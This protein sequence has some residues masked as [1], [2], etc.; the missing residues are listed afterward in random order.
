MGVLRRIVGIGF[1]FIFI[2]FLYITVKNRLVNISA[3]SFY[4]DAS[5]LLYSIAGMILWLLIYEIAWEWLFRKVCA[6]NTNIP[7]HITGKAFFKSLLA[8]YTPGQVWQIVVRTESLTQYQIPRKQTIHSVLYEQLDFIVATVTYT[9]IFAPF[10]M[11]TSFAKVS[12]LPFVV[13]LPCVS[14]FVILWLFTPKK[15]VFLLNTFFSKISG[16]EKL[17]LLEIKSSI[18]Q[19]QVGFFLFFIVVCLQ[20]LILYPLI[21]SLIPDNTHL[22]FTQWIVLMS[23]YPIARMIGQFAIIFPGGMGVREGVYIVLLSTFIDSSTSSIV[24]VWAR[25]LQIF[26]EILMFIVFSL[27]HLIKGPLN[28]K[29]RN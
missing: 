16:K 28:N 2:F 26:S 21:Q 10:F 27:I 29:K 13:V 17:E 22:T 6:L 8:R 1:T 25:L 23:A 9:L 24:A 18:L 4:P 7:W 15:F 5:S 14:I 11:M 20:G 19:W 3:F 12:M